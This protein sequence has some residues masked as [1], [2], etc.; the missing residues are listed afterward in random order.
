MRRI[1]WRFVVWLL[2]LSALFRGGLVCSGRIDI[3]SE[4]PRPSE[5]GASE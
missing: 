4:K 2:V 3:V 5:F 1:D